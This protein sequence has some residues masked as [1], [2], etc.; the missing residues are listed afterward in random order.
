MAKRVPTPAS[1]VSAALG[2]RRSGGGGAG[3]A[4]GGGGV[5]SWLALCVRGNTTERMVS[6]RDFYA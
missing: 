3:G 6:R 2:P 5:F 4:G 1:F